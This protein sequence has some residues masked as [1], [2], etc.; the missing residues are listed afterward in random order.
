VATSRVYIEEGKNA[1]FAISLDWPGWCRRAKSADLAIEALDTYRNRYAQI[2]TIPF[3][4]GS[5]EVVGI[6]KGNA[7]TDFGAPDARG[8]WDEEPLS[9]AALS[10]Q[11]AVLQDCWNYFDAVVTN[12][13]PTLRRGPRGGGRDPDQIVDHVREAERA[14]CSRV[15]FR[16]PPRTPWDEQRD[17]VVT[18]L[19]ANT[20]SA[21]WP[22]HY[23]LRRV[24]WHIV[25]HAWEIE[26][27]SE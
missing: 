4:P 6:L 22:A 2:V 26:D 13:P 17:V 10:R 15:G 25:D 1:V 12:A 20:P 24:A 21:K 7:T 19:R 18:A 23:A 8:P 27:K 9:S 11:I 14:Y 5:F 3:R 16:M